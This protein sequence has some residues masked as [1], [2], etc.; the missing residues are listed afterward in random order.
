MRE[1]AVVAAVVVLAAGVGLAVH[2]AD[3]RRNRGDD[4]RSMVEGLDIADLFR[5]LLTLVA[6]LLAFV[7]VQTFSSFQDASDSAAEEATAVLSEA[8]AARRLTAPSAT[9]I[10]GG[11]RCYALAVAGPGWEALAATRLTSPVTEEA[12]DRVEEDLV[13]A[14][15]VVDDQPELDA[16]LDADNA[17]IAARR[18]RLSEARPSVPTLVTVLLII[19]VAIIVGGSAALTNRRVRLPYSVPL[20]AA[21][22]VVF[23]GSL[24]V[25]I[26][27]D[28]KFGGFARIEPVELRDVEQR[29]ADLTPGVPPP[30]DERGQPLP[31]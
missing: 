31:D 11:L 17:R 9:S 12:N 19:S 16:V 10:I 23:A 29:L 27:L 3:V 30:C 7:L 28:Q 21:T 4:D 20:I 18:N 24:V 5:P 22:V 1:L 6:L 13:E 8:Q 2:V 14:S 26:D 25:I 15:E